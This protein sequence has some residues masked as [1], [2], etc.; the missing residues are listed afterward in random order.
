MIPST[1]SRP[2]CSVGILGRGG[3]CADESERQKL[4]TAGQGTILLADILT[5]PPVLH[6][7]D[8]LLFRATDISS[9]TI[10]YP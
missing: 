2:H 9:R 6:P 7:Y 1:D 4:I 5:T 3:R 8:P 10:T